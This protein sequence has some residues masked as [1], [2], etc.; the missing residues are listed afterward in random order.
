MLTSP[1]DSRSKNREP[2][3]LPAIQQIFS[4]IAETQNNVAY[5]DLR[6]IMGGENSVNNWLKYKLAENDKLHYTKAGYDL[7]AQLLI[8]A[9]LKY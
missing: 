7:Q 4:E 3:S 5:W 1:P 8:K 6:S 2:V 9:L